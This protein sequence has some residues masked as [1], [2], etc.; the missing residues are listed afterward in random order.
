MTELNNPRTDHSAFERAYGTGDN[1]P[2][3]VSPFSIQT[4]RN[5]V[6]GFASTKSRVY[7]PP[8]R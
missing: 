8:G 7:E 1:S 3:L 5:G 4:L 2:S 6:P